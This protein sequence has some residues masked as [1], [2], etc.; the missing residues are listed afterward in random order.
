VCAVCT[1]IVSP[2]RRPSVFTGFDPAA[3]AAAELV[4]V[5]FQRNRFVLLLAAK[6]PR[7]GPDRGVRGLRDCV[8]GERTRQPRDDRCLRADSDNDNNYYY[9][10]I[11]LP[12]AR[13]L[14]SVSY[15]LPPRRIY[16]SDGL[17]LSG[18]V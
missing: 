13:V 3:A 16:R 5:R 18:I 17:L 1:G 2:P 11:I 4:G 10:D 8:P 9:D 14:F 15:R 12:R 7:T 6:T